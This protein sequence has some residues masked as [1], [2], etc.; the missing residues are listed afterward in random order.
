MLNRRDGHI[1]KLTVEFN[2]ALN[3]STHKNLQNV[4]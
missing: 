2:D 3:N 4:S 1:S